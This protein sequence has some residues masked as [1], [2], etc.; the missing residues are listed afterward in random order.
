MEGGYARLQSTKIRYN[1]NIHHRYFPAHPQHTIHSRALQQD[2][3]PHPMNRFVSAHVINQLLVILVKSL[4]RPRLG[5]KLRLSKYFSPSDCEGKAQFY[6]IPG[7]ICE[8]GTKDSL[9]AT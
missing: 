8:D 9:L 2:L 1:I 4:L 6:F 7:A 3:I 5:F